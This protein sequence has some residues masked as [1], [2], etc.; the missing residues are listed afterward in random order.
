MTV[1]KTKS[2]EALPEK[3]P[4]V[5]ICGTV[6]DPHVQRVMEK[7]PSNGVNAVLLD[8]NE[9]STV[10]VWQDRR[11]QPVVSINGIEVRP[12]DPRL[13][14][15]SRPKTNTAVPFF[16]PRRSSPDPSDPVRLSTRTLSFLASEWTGMYGL[17]N[18]LFADRTVNKP[19]SVWRLRSKVVQQ[20]LAG[21]V[22][23]PVPETMLTNDY[24]AAFN[25]TSNGAT[26]IKSHT[27][28]MI[29]SDPDI[30][31]DPGGNMLTMA[32]TIE[33]LQA[34][35]IEQFKLVPSLMQRQIRKQYELRI[36]YV[37][38]NIF[39]FRVDSQRY[40]LTSVDWRYGN[41]F[42]PFQPWT[43]SQSITIKIHEL[44][45]RMGL[46]FG[47]IDIIVDKRG[48]HWFLEVNPDG[49]W[50]WLDDIVDGAISTHFATSLL[51][52]VRTNAASSEV[53]VVDRE[54]RT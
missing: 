54:G 53:R 17:M 12:D 38:G 51:E 28:P 1:N 3:L 36:C 5:L 8:H 35:S 45:S 30:D 25:F 21:S 42:L 37:A 43:L 6:D 15:W 48:R 46:F 20:T 9:R 47:F 44:M 4:S 26:I 11:G 19:D 41:A 34:T 2:G 33:A 13:L 40:N 22:G 23:F 27:N 49:A 52:Q 24:E 39:S 18:Q 31:D 14:I 32:V 16:F 29:E 7:L 10:T 50:A